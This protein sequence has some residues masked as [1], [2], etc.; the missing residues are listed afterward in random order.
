MKTT[1]RLGFVL[2][3]GLLFVTAADAQPRIL[4]YK[5][6]SDGVDKTPEVDWHERTRR[7]ETIKEETRDGVVVKSDQTVS[8]VLPPD[9]RR[10]YTKVIDSG[11]TTENEQIQITDFLYTRINGGPWDKVDLRKLGSGRGYGSGYGSGS[12]RTTCS[13]YSIESTVVN[14]TPVNLFQH[15]LLYTERNEILFE[16]RRK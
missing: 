13:Q 12:S 7:V 11:K 6:Y 3:I 5:E 16:E 1:Y 14:G 2:L 8:E 10:T 15:I 4:T 9:R